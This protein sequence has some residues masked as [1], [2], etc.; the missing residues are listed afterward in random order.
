M[1]I[2]DHRLVRSKERI[3]IAIRQSVRMLRVRF[4]FE[5]IDYINEPDFDIREFLSQQ[6]G[7]RQGLLSRYVA[8][9]SEDHVG[10][11]PL[12]GTRPIPDS[13]GLR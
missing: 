2:E 10:F 11:A 6:H 1:K 13:Y 3:E 7:C 12:I 9:R 4:E 8:G 5:E